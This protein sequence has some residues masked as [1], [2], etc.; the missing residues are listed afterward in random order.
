MSIGVGQGGNELAEWAL[1]ARRVLLEE[2]QDSEIYRDELVRLWVSE[3]FVS[4]ARGQSPEQTAISYFNELVNRSLIQPVQIDTDG[5][6]QRA[7]STGGC[8]DETGRIRLDE[9]PRNRGWIK[10]SRP[11]WRRMTRGGM[12]R[13][14]RRW[15]SSPRRM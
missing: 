6:E 2:V 10:G 7:S 13:R 11:R 12:G 15:A 8:W 1:E 5:S 14:V 4:K 9:I 3:G